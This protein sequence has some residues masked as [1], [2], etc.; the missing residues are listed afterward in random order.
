MRDASVTQCDCETCFEATHVVFK[1][2][3]YYDTLGNKIM[4]WWCITMLSLQSVAEFEV[5]RM[6]VTSLRRDPGHGPRPP[7]RTS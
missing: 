4:L 1:H 5:Q 7:P 2:N 6:W 3:I